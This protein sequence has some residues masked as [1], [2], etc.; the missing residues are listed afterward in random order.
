MRR[1]LVGCAVLV[2]VAVTGGSAALAQSQIALVGTFTDGGT[3]AP[4]GGALTVTR[5][6]AARRTVLAS[7]SAEVSFCLPDVDPKNC[8]ATFDFPVS[9]GVT[10]VSATCDEVTVDLAPIHTVVGD[11][12]TLDLAVANPLVLTG[13]LRYLR[14]TL[15]F[16]VKYHAPAS[17]LARFLNP[18]LSD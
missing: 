14:C 17:L 8:L 12:F 16:L 15:A 11:R 10:H 9:T 13:G 3:I 4:A 5:F 2:L 6:S 7:G 18:L 1:L